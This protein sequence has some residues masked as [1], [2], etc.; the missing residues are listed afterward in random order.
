MIAENNKP[1]AH[2]PAEESPLAE[3]SKLWKK[4]GTHSLTALLVAL[5]IVM[6]VRAFIHH[7]AQSKLRA[8]EMLFTAG[9]QQQ[10]EEITLNY[11]AAPAAPLALLELASRHFDAG[12][13]GQARL[14]YERFI[15]RYGAHEF[16]NAAELGRYFCMEAEGRINEALVGFSGFILANP[17]DFM[18]PQAVQAKGRCLQELGRLDEARILYEDFIASN[19]DS[20]WAQQMEAALALVERKIQQAAKPAPQAVAENENPP[21]AQAA[22]PEHENPPETAIETTETAVEPQAAP[23]NA[24][25]PDSQ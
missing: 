19:P 25:E 7:K 17:K 11:A 21:A 9:S 5:V 20:E 4:Y 8:L 3:L 13:Y 2:S 15:E 6:G 22:T 18:T 1:P 24:I 12:N 16:R 14:S 10:L 23:E